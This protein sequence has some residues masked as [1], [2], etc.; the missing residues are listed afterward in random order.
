MYHSVAK[1]LFVMA[2]CTTIMPSILGCKNSIISWSMDTNF[3]NFIAK[4][5]F[6]TYLIHLTVLDIWIKSRT[7]SRYL[8]IMPTVPEF[9]AVLG[10]SLLFGLI[11]TFLI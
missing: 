10:V 8:K 4:I 9:M 1:I 5:S 7:N 11:M 3:F 6:C 2:L